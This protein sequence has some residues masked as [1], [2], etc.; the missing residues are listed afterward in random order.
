MAS[1]GKAELH[2]LEVGYSATVLGRSVRAARK[3]GSAS[4]RAWVACLRKV[5]EVDPV[6][7]AKCGGGMDLVAVILDDLELDRVLGH[8]GWSVEF[9]RPKPS[10]SPPARGPDAD[11]S[12]VDP[13]GEQWEGRQDGMG[14]GP[15]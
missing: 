10:R 14:D 13:R 2:E 7:C 11:D 1:R 9:P 3:A 5:F 8:Q 12:Q 4:V 6:L 15:A